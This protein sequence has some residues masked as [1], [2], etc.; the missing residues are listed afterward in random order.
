MNQK[1]VGT[2]V[3]DVAKSII[4]RLTPT[5]DE[6]NETMVKNISSSSKYLDSQAQLGGTQ[7][8]ERAAGI[9]NDEATGIA[10]NISAK[11]LDESIES[12]RDDIS[13]IISDDTDIDKVLAAMKSRSSK[14]I[15]AEPSVES[16]TE[17]MKSVLGVPVEKYEQ[18]AKAYF[19]NPDKQIK[20]TRIAAA[21]TAYAGIAIGG[22]Y[23]SGGTL[24]TD[25]YGRKDIAGVPFL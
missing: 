7:A 13:K 18:Y 21:T 14:N 11:N 5:V 8:L 24:T 3:Q 1:I 23:L 22:R 20:N 4:G 10:K 15:E 6:L 19:T 2:K 17:N 9:S 16:V 25:S 12:L